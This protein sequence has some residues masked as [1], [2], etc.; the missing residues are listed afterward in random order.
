MLQ[1][2]AM[3]EEEDFPTAREFLEALRPG[4]RRWQPHSTCWLFR[5]QSDSQWPLIPTAA[6]DK[7]WVPFSEQRPTKSYV[8]KLRAFGPLVF[9]ADLLR[10]FAHALDHAGLPIPGASRADIESLPVMINDYRELVP[11][12]L[13][14][15]ALAQHHGVPTRLLDFTRHGLIAAYF[16]AAAK[17]SRVRDTRLCVWAI[18]GRLSELEKRAA[19]RWLSI[20]TA[21]RAINAHLRAQEGVFFVWGTEQDFVPLDEVVL[22]MVRESPPHFMRQ[23][24]SSVPVLRRLTLPTSEV[25]ELLGLLVNERISGATMFPGIN[26]VVRGMTERHRHRVGEYDLFFS[27]GLPRK[28]ELPREDEGKTSPSG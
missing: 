4:D 18:D 17:P 2:L 22:A 6:R 1:L 15:I 13:E 20:Y 19:R 25:T 26:G 11:K 16:A 3:I 10:K 27:R 23:Q 7:C 5:G 12:Y 8:D 9:E 21:T 14:L 28:V 24:G